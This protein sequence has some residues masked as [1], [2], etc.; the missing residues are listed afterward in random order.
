M[1]ASTVASNKTFGVE[2]F[3]EISIDIGQQNLFNSL[4]NFI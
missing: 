3:S 4:K 2:E 1:T